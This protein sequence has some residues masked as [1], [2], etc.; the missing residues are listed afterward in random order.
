VT[1][2]NAAIVFGHLEGSTTE[3]A[4]EVVVIAASPG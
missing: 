2:K 4:L 3:Y 1:T